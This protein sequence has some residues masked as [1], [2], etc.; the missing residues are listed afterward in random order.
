MTCMLMLL[1][2]LVCAKVRCCS[3][4]LE[5]LDA[6]ALFRAIGHLGK[7]SGAFPVEKPPLLGATPDEVELWLQV[8]H[9]AR[10]SAVPVE[11]D[12]AYA[13][14]HLLRTALPLVVVVV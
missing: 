13:N 1:N 10:G 6:A 9:A 14:L 2:G 12:G 3:S 7:Q 5:L 11:G 8:D 4:R